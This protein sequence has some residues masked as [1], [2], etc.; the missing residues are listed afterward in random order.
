MKATMSISLATLLIKC[1]GLSQGTLDQQYLPSGGNGLIVQRSSTVAQT[2]EVGLSGV[3]NGVEV[4]LARNAAVL[5]EGMTL[6][7]R[8]TL[9]DGS[10]ASGV[11]ASV[12]ISAADL[13]TAFQFISI[14]L[15]S[16]A[17][18]VNGGDMF[19]L[20]LRSDAV[21]QGGGID[22]YAWGGEAPGG[23][24]RGSVYLDCGT[25][26]VQASGWDVGFRSYVV[27]EPSSLA[28]LLCGTTVLICIGRR[29]GKGFDR[30]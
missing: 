24:S 9:P 20:V 17:L 11:L 27:P 8:S 14:D 5:S 30:L 21:A 7:I 12:P 4:Q 15:L 29:H 28:L 10:P 13:S 2:F 1:V 19:A 3:L 6:E 23:Y 25:G 18:A 26:F 16:F 22:P